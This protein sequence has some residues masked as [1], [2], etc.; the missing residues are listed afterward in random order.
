MKKKIIMIA[1]P[2][3]VMLVLVIF[4]LATQ[5]TI[6]T[7]TWQLNRAYLEDSHET[8]AYGPNSDNNTYTLFFP[9]LQYIFVFYCKIF[10]K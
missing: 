6:S 8:V 3:L 1:I 4:S 9:I 7:R 2:V 5:V 10:H